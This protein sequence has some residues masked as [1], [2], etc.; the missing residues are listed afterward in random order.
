MILVTNDD[1]IDSPG[2]QAAVEAVSGLADIL[3][4][5]P[6]AQMTSM[7]RS[8]WGAKTALFQ[9]IDYEANGRAVKAYHMDCSPARLVLHALDVL[10]VDQKPDLIVSG[11]NYGE[12]LGSNVT[13]S[14]TIG[15]VLQGACMGIPGLAVSLQTEIEN[16]HVHADLNWG[17]ARHFTKKFARMM[18][19]GDLPVGEEILNVNVPAHATTETQWRVTRQSRQPYFTNIVRIPSKDRSI[20]DG[21]CVIGYDENSLEPDSDIS[22]IVHDGVVSVSP[23][24]VDLTAQELMCRLKEMYE[25]S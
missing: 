18:L 21:E 1:G 4:V 8:L 7:G 22:A 5:A 20:G 12:N 2:L 6:T 25:K 15:A 11:V 19:S 3:V 10:C 23:L 17:A 13:I 24:G 14:A 9:P 16:H